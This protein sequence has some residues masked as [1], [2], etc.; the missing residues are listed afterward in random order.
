VSDFLLKKLSTLA[1]LDQRDRQLVDQLSR[2]VRQFEKGQ[3]IIGHG[4]RPD[5]LHLMVEPFVAMGLSTAL[6][7]YRWTGYAAAGAVL[8]ISGLIVALSARR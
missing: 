5:H 3:E 6:E 4:E 2:D 8:T 1:E 7:G